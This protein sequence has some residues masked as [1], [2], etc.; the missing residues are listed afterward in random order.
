MRKNTEGYPVVSGCFESHLRATAVTD[1]AITGI[2]EIILKICFNDMRPD[3]ERKE[4]ELEVC[5][6]LESNGL[7]KE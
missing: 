6:S 4:V 5:E 1:N 3:G 7:Q 2:T